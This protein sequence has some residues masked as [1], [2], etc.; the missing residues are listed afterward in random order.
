MNRFFD[1]TSRQLK[2]V[3]F[4]SA[5]LLVTSVLN[6]VRNISAVEPEAMRLTVRVGDND[7]RYSPLFKVD[8]NHSPVDSLELLPGIGP[9]LAQR[10][11]SYRDSVGPYRSPEDLMKVRGIGFKLYDKIKPYLEVRPW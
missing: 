9:I 6:L 2:F 10:I 11:V 3:I 1:F 7:T 4:L 8:L 5:L